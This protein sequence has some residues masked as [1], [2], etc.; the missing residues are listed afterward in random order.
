[1]EDGGDVLGHAR[2]SS[3]RPRHFI[4][5]ARLES[6]Q[7]LP[8]SDGGALPLSYERVVRTRGVEP[9]PSRSVVGCSSIEPR[10]DVWTVLYRLSYPGSDSGGW[11]LHQHHRPVGMA[12]FEPTTSWSQARRATYC[13][14]SRWLVPEVSNPRLDVQSVTCCHLHQGPMLVGDACGIRTH[15][16]QL[17]GLLS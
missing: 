8:P 3:H 15:T 4:Q 1:M 7:R 13:A 17:E 2:T 6:N 11:P 10:A 12:G 5:T 16:V 9:L 14:T